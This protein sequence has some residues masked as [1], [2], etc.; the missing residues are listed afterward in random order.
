MIPR[1]LYEALPY[2]YFVLGLVAL[3]STDPIYGKL[4]GA[5]LVLTSVAIRKMRKAYRKSL[6]EL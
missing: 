4:A 3:L 2:L 5:M 6:G 1:P